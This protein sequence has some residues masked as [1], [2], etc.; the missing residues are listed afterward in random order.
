LRLTPNPSPIGRGALRRSP[1][2]KTLYYWVG[3]KTLNEIK[4]F[5]FLKSSL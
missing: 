3:V 2:E 5:T 1:F 4:L